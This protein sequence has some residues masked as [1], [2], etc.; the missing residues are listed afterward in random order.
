MEIGADAEIVSQ[1]LR[2][3]RRKRTMTASAVADAM[4]MA[5]RTFEEFE[6]GRGP[7]TFA[8]IC[9]FTEATDSDPFALMLCAPFKTP[10]FAV[11]CADTK[12]VMIMM[13][14]LEEFVEREGSYIVFLEPPYLIGGFER[15]F[16]EF[17]GKLSDRENFLQ[18]WF[19]KRTGSIGLS[20]LRLRE[21][22]RRSAKP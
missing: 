17:S 3:I 5:L 22:R 14:H 7:I 12:L 11:D 19:E 1:A 10:A 13:M 16:R 8:R 6:A 18:N 4:G 20:A 2:A 21:R 15:V 9:A